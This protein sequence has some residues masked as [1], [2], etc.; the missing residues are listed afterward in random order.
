MTKRRAGRKPKRKTQ[1]LEEYT[2][3]YSTGWA[4]ARRKAEGRI[5][6]TRKTK[7]KLKSADYQ[8]GMA[9]GLKAGKRCYGN[10]KGN[11]A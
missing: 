2:K 4:R 9:D 10:G 8:A 11:K 6:I 3:G 7:D 1:N 5:P